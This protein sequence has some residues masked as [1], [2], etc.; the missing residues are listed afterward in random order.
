[1]IYDGFSFFEVYLH[2]LRGPQGQEALLLGKRATLP[3][4]LPQERPTTQP[5]PPQRLLPTMGMPRL[6]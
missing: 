4:L 2:F 6:L 3:L 1:L 5:L